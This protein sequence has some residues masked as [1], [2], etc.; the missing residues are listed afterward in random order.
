[1]R[2]LSVNAFSHVSATA[3][4]FPSPAS[5][6]VATLLRTDW[7]KSDDSNSVGQD[8]P[9]AGSHSSVWVHL[10]QRRSCQAFCVIL[11]CQFCV[12]SIW[13]ILA[14]TR[15]LLFQLSCCSCAIVGSS[16]LSALGRY[17]PWLWCHPKSLVFL[18]YSAISGLSF[19]A[20]LQVQMR[21]QT[22]VCCIDT[23]LRAC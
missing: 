3:T 9:S 22:T 1:M 2:F 14:R 7:G 19:F 6:S 16:Y 4:F 17:S 11:L 15:I 5:G 8:T 20:R 21:R 10:L 23:D 12:R 18:E 13:L